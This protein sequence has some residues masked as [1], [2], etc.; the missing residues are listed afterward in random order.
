MPTYT[1]Y[2]Y[3]DGCDLHGVA[4]EIESALIALVR[5]REWSCD[6]WVVNQRYPPDPGDSPE[7]LPGWDLGLNHELP[8]IGTDDVGWFADVEFIVVALAEL[9]SGC[10]RMFA[11]GLVN[12]DTDIGEDVHFVEAGV[13]DLVSLRQM[14][15]VDF[16]RSGDVRPAT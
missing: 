8:D 12:D 4:Q 3:V 14:L 16:P 6:T 7:M 10:G 5:S 11:I 15:G 2:A 1:L 13:P 9:A